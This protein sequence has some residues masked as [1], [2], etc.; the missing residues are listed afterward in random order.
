MNYFDIN[1]IPEANLDS[2]SIT[3]NGSTLNM[4]WNDVTWMLEDEIR[5]IDSY[6]YALKPLDSNTPISVL[7]GGLGL[8]TIAEYLIANKNITK[9]DVLES[10][11]DITNWT[12]NSGHLNSLVNIIETDATTYRPTQNYDLIIMDLWFPR[13]DRIKSEVPDMKA[14]YTPYL[15]SGGTL[16]IPIDSYY[17]TSS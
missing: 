7:M 12:N 3:H 1:D 4:V 5:Y 6:A 9:F 10:N 11:L 15:N 14:R 2:I 16:Y 13:E 8:G 17:Y